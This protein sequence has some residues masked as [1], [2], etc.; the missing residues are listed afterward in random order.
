[1]SGL[2]EHSKSSSRN[3]HRLKSVLLL[4]LTLILFDTPGTFG[5][6][7]AQDATKGN[8]PKPPSSATPRNTA[9]ED[10]AVA[11]PSGASSAGQPARTEE[12]ASVFTK[13]IEK[14]GLSV[15]FEL[16]RTN[17]Q[18]GSNEQNR[19]RVLTENDDV[20]FSFRIR[21]AA[22][23][24]PLSG[25][26]PAAWLTLAN[27][28]ATDAKGCSDRVQTLL[29]GSLL[30]RADLD[31][32]TYFV[33]ALNN[34]STITVVDP[35]FGYGGTKLLA[36]IRLKS[37]GD[38]WVITEN[39]ERVFVSL[40]A[41]NQVAM[42]DPDSWSV[43]ASLDVGPGP[44]RL[45]LQ[46]DEAYLWVAL[47]GDRQT[48]KDSGVAAFSLKTLKPVARFATGRGPHE[49]AFSDDNKFAFVTNPDDQSV[50][51]IDIRR[52]QKL[53][54]IRIGS[55]AGAIA[56]S[57]LAKAAYVT[58]ADSG[59]ITVISS[60]SLEVMARIRTHPGIEQIKFAPGEQL[61]FV[62]NPALDSVYIV[63]AA[64]NRVIQKA[65]LEKGPDQVAFTSKIAYIRHRDSEQVLMIPLKELGVEGQPVPVLDFPGGQNPLGKTSMP[66]RADSI[67]AAAT[68]SAVLVANP[69]DQAIYYYQ[70]GMAAPMG[71]FSNYGREPRAVLIVDRS[72]RETKA[73]YYEA[74][75]RLPRGG[76]YNLALF[77]NSPRVVDCIDLTIASTSDHQTSDVKGIRIEALTRQTTYKPGEPVR[78][79]FRVV[80]SRTE[81]PVAG[82]RDLLALT[83]A[84]GVWQTRSVLEDLGDGLYEFSIVPP[85]AGVYEVFMTSS[86]RKLAY[87][88]VFTFEAG[89]PN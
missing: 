21:D 25:V 17:E 65:D 74:S 14:Q 13:R 68:E 72:M 67:V 76:R 5:I 53:E 20:N 85:A 30:A 48:G 33:L 36:M 63:D 75:A 31:L 87:T 61:A 52:L 4:S 82:L 54:D 70:E 77:I 69:A 22:T 41:S 51:V 37:P 19:E 81:K 44:S 73:G 10:P 86:S 1:M 38:D 89:K 46:P 9:K 34:D 12:S 6:A 39:Q 50:T 28:N 43:A 15:D 71:N 60:N 64:L 2:V 16:R 18:D 29:G 24:N 83:I 47:Q 32:N 55:K 49:I 7:R 62:L 45:A 56:Y 66:S 35:L 11:A 42:I 27:D 80:D 88:L 40:P 26:G 79:R 84:A 58:S 57:K 23:G 59:V 8:P 78:P 3:N